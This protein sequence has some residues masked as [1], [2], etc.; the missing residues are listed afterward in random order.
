MP[1]PLTVE[2]AVYFPDKRKRDL[3]NL[4]KCLLDALTHAGVY[5]DDK[6]IEDLRIYKA[7]YEKDGKVIVAVEVMP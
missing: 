4:L 6:Q 2:V 1:G 5:E 7:G 3:D